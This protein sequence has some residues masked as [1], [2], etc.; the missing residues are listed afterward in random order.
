MALQTSINR[1]N[2]LRNS[3]A[4]AREIFLRSERR[5]KVFDRLVQAF[6][7]DQPHCI[8]R[9]P[10]LGRADGV[11]RHDVRVLQAAGYLRFAQ[12]AAS[13]FLG[14]TL[15]RLGAEPSVPRRGL[16]DRHRFDGD[17][18]PQGF[19]PGLEH[20][21]HPAPA[22]FPHELEVLQVGRQGD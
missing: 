16:A 20:L 3:K 6:A 12:E 18:S 7:F 4:R 17:A 13:Q 19:L 21:P 8:V 9:L 14:V 10:I 11:H 22:D 1:R 2:S 5:V 15:G